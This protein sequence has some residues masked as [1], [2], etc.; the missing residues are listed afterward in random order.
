MPS[1]IHDTLFMPIADSHNRRVSDISY[2][3]LW[4]KG[5][6]T[7]TK[8]YFNVILMIWVRSGRW[9]CLVTWFCYQRIAKPG[10]KT[11]PPSWPDPYHHLRSRMVCTGV[12]YQRL[13]LA[14]PPARDIISCCIWVACRSPVMVFKGAALKTNRFTPT[15]EMSFHWTVSNGL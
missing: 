7:T 5:E 1:I 4:D 2:P 8:R 13:W 14:V 11:V 10:N 12:I 6:I 9:A 15:T 3:E